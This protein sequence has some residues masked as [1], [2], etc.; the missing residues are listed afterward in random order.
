M[1]HL[2]VSSNK[3]LKSKKPT[4]IDLFAGAGGMSEALKT[5][6]FELQGAIE[7][8]KVFAS[9][10]E[11]NHGQHVWVDDIRKISCQEFAG[12]YNVIPRELDLLAG[13]S[14]CQGFSK[15]FSYK[16]KKKKADNDLTEIEPDEKK[17]KEEDERNLLVF[18]Y[19]RFVHYFSPKYILFENVPGILSHPQIFNAFITKLK[20]KRN[21][22]PG[23]DIHYSTINAADYG[24]PQRRKRLVLI[25][26]RR[27]INNGEFIE[28][29]Y[30]KTTHYNPKKGDESEGKNPWVSL[31]EVIRHLPHIQA[32]ETHVTDPLHFSKNISPENKIRLEHT[33]HNGGGRKDWPENLWLNCHKPDKENVGY[34]DV[35]GRMNYDT[36]SSTLTG[37]CLSIAKGR[38]A[39]PEQNRAIS[40]REAAI[41]Q[42]FPVNYVFNGTKEQIAMQ[43]GNA[44]PVKMGLAFANNIIKEINFINS[45]VKKVNETI[46]ERNFQRVN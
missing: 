11:R 3:I 32:G 41:I 21:N 12:I 30:P 46:E 29:L 42:T 34:G 15:Q 16:N 8:D 18:E 9:T 26:K 6:G 44:V 33:P 14:P 19:L 38:F 31:G 22:F 4:A 36:V 13:C 40:A 17:E 27:D 25:G 24:V 28:N 5:A 37:G 10:Y 2:K 7:Y 39:H 43:I 20:R 1:L 45:E 23:Y 35:Y